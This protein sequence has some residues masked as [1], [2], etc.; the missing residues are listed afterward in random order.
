MTNAEVAEA[1]AVLARVLD[2][3]L[4]VPR[5]RSTATAADL[6]HTAGALAAR[7]EDAIRNAALGADL[8]RCFD[9]AREAGGTADAFGRVRHAIVG[10]A[11]ITLPATLIAQASVRFA[12]VQE[13]LVIA[14]TVFTS[15]EDVDRALARIGGAFQAA[16]EYAADQED[17]SAY[18]ALVALRGAVVR[19]LNDRA[20][21]LPRIVTYRRPRET[22]VLTLANYL[23]GDG[24]RAEELMRENP[25]AVHPL[26]MPAE[27]R[28]LSA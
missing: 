15:R 21:P 12:L 2:A 7:S 24:D 6:R 25:R 1:Q 13:S 5:D 16:E 27:G 17:A 14:E 20:R 26:F 9:L 28:A 8:R 4:A 19:D 10:V 18:R 23:Y 11:T 3:L 22:P